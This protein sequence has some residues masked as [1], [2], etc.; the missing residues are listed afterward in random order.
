[1]VL[2][3]VETMRHTGGVAAHCEH[4]T[5]AMMKKRTSVKREKLPPLMERYLQIIEGKIPPAHWPEILAANVTYNGARGVITEGFDAVAMQLAQWHAVMEN[6]RIEMIRMVEDLEAREHRDHVP[7]LA[8]KIDFWVYSDW[9]SAPK[10]SGFR[11][12]IWSSACTK[13]ATTRFGRS[14]RCGQGRA[15]HRQ[16]GE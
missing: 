7:S 4:Q 16:S 13:Y 11:P 5:E 14:M 12:R 6:I 8:M 1:M 3:G 10:P 2:V 9:V 15:S